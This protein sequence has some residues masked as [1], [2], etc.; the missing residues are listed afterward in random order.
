MENRF[1]AYLT[2]ILTSQVWVKAEAPLAS[3][4]SLDAEVVLRPGQDQVIEVITV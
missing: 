4:A 3:G 1:T 2:C